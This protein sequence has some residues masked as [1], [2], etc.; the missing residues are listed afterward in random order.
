MKFAIKSGLLSIIFSLPVPQIAFGQACVVYENPGLQG[1]A[2]RFGVNQT[3]ENLTQADVVTVR[4]SDFGDPIMGRTN[5]GSSNGAPTG[6]TGWGGGGG[7]TTGQPN[8]GNPPPQIVI[9]REFVS[10]DDK[11]SSV[12]VGKNCLLE[13]WEHPGFQG[14][15]A[16]F[17]EGKYHEMNNFPHDSASSLKCLCTGL[18]MIPNTKI[19]YLLP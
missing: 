17:G 11:V 5:T 3:V 7:S 9:S 16:A 2:M 14:L 15:R 1:I 18:A 10:F 6:G 4:R 12:E 8:V 13:I 19:V